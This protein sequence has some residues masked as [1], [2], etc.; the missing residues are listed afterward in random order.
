LPSVLAAAFFA[1]AGALLILMSAAVAY[2]RTDLQGPADADPSYLS[3][4]SVAFWSTLL[5]FAAIGVFLFAT[6]F[7]FDYFD[8]AA[9]RHRGRCWRAVRSSRCLFRPP[10]HPF[11]AVAQPAKLAADRRRARS[12]AAAVWLA[13]AT[14]AGN[15]ID[16]PAQR[17]FQRSRARR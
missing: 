5:P 4:L 11:G 2:R 9:R 17:D 15:G 8:G 3:R 16:L 13:T 12:G 14:G 6:W 1:V 7:F 10:A